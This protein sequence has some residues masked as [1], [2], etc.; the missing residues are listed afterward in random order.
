MGRVGRV[1]GRP[2][3]FEAGHRGGFLGFRHVESIFVLTK[4]LGD[5]PEI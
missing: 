2:S 1:S 4:G 3:G 5:I